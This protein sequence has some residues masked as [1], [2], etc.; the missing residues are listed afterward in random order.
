MINEIDL[1]RYFELKSTSFEMPF[2]FAR[3]PGRA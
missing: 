2:V 3:T 1:E